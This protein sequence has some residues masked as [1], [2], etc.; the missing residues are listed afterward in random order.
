MWEGREVAVRMLFSNRQRP[1]DSEC[2]RL[3]VYPS[4]TWNV[5][6][7]FP[8]NDPL[9]WTIFAGKYIPSHKYKSLKWFGS[10]VLLLSMYL[11]TGFSLYIQSA[12]ILTFRDFLLW[13]VAGRHGI[14]GVWGEWPS[15]FLPGTPSSGQS[16]IGQSLIEQ[17]PKKPLWAPTAQHSS[18]GTDVGT[19]APAQRPGLY[20]TNYHPLTEFQEQSPHLTSKVTLVTIRVHVS[21][22]LTVFSDCPTLPAD[23][24]CLLKTL[25]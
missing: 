3:L 12:I 19:L 7:P 14:H 16:L 25:P 9:Y 8:V 24:S 1:R 23:V 22:T 2:H 17:F 21:Q 4:C 15:Q 11:Y 6:M 10:W 18:W 20:W 5:S 13:Y